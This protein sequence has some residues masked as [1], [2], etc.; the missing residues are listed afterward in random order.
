MS[1][2]ARLVCFE[3]EQSE[4]KRLTRPKLNRRFRKWNY[5]SHKLSK[6]AKMP[7]EMKNCIKEVRFKL[8]CGV[9]EKFR[10]LF[11]RLSF[12]LIKLVHGKFYK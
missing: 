10:H 1:L 6:R 5:N 11:Y 2:S 8:V 3:Y 9:K 12:K 4:H 7:M